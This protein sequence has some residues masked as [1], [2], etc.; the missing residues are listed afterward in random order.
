MDKKYNYRDIEFGMN[1]LNHLVGDD[2][3]VREWLRDDEHKQLLEEL[4]RI[5][6]GVWRLSVRGSRMSMENG[7]S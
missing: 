6:K 7:K 1:V 4:R 3:S 2:E 5:R